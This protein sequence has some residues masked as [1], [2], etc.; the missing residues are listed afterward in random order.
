[1]IFGKLQASA[2]AIGV[3][4][5]F[6]DPRGAIADE[7]DARELIAKMS[8]FVSQQQR[9]SFSYD[10][11][12]EVVTTD[13]Q[14][15]SLTSSGSIAID[16]P[17]RI[18]AMRQGGFS[19]VEFHFDGNV[20][21]ALDVLQNIYVKKEFTGTIDEVIEVLR[22]TYGHP[23]PGADLLS[24]DIEAHLMEYVTDVKDLGSGIVRGVECDHFAFRTPDLDWQIWIAQ[25]DEPYPCRYMITTNTGPMAPSYTFDLFDW[26]AEATED[27]LEFRLPAGAREIDETAIPQ[28]DELSGFYVFAGGN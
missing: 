23:I 20:F 19:T 18:R 10:S 22:N 2:L 21:A 15:L 5:S 11:S 14:K 27:A 12:L 7:A 28:F 13:E 25:G 24:S 6:F 1:M 9:L 16:R 26:S 3:V 8:Q 4:C 17:H